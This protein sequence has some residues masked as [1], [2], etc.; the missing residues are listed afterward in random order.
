MATEVRRTVARGAVFAVGV[1]LLVLYWPVVTVTG[2]VT[3]T[4][5]VVHCLVFAI[6]TYL[7]ARAWGALGLTVLA[8]AVH[9]GLSEA[10]QATLLP[11]RSGDPWDVALDLLGVAAGAAAVL[12][13]RRTAEASRRHW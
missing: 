8:F 11:G 5:K 2:P 10:V 13:R 6:P 7:V 12:A 9:A 4:D 1:Q 3:W